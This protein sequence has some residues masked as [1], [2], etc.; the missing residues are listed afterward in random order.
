MNRIL[1]SLCLRLTLMLV[2]LVASGTGRAAVTFQ[3]AGTALA[4]TNVIG[5]LA[6]TWPAHVQGDVALLF[7]ESRAEEAV[8]L[9]Q[10]N[11]FAAVANTPQS[12]GSGLNGT[13]LTVFWA[14]ATSA[15]MLPP[16]ITTPTNHVYARI[17]TYRGVINNGD[18]I[19]AT[20]GDV[21]AGASGSVTVTGVT[22][23]VANTLIV[24]AVARH[25]DN[26]A[27][28]F[29]AQTNINLAGISEQLDAGTAN[30]DGGG[31]GVWSGTKATAGATGDTTA[32][33]TSSINAFVTI[34]LKPQP[35]PRF[36][37]AGT[38]VGN[39]STA[40]PAWPAHAINDIA[41][42]FVESGGGEIVTLSVAAG[43]APVLNSP[44]ATGATTAGTRLT[45][46]WARATSAAMTAPTVTVPVV[47]NS[48]IYA[49]IITFRGVATAGNPWDV[50]GGGVKT[51]TSTVLSVT[52]VS[53]MVAD[54]LLVQAVARDARSTAAYA[55]NQAN[56][57][58]TGIAERVDA[59]TNTGLG[60]GFAVW[61]GYKATAGATG[62]TTATMVNSIN[63][64]LS[65]A[66]IPQAATVPVFN[67]LGTAVVAVAP[68]L[69]WP[70]HLVDDIALVF[71]ESTGGQAV[72]LLQ[73]NGFAA[74]TN[75][76]QATGAGTAGTRISVFWARAT[77]A[78]MLGPILG[79]TTDH[80]YAQIL[81]Y[82]GVVN[83]GNP[84][85]TTAPVGGV[86][87]AASTAVTVTGVTTTYANAMVVQAVARDNDNA[88]A[89]FSAQTNANL[90]SIAERVDAGTTNG[91]GG[92]FSVWDGTKV[93]AGATGNT[94]ATVTSSINAFLTVAL[95]PAGGVAPDH[96]ELSLATDSVSCV[97]TPVTV[98]ACTDT[99]SPC[100]NNF[101]AAS[102]T[103]ATLGTS[104]GALG[105][106]N[107]TFNASGVA[108]TTLNYAAAADG[109]TAI[110]TLSG[111]ALAATNP[112]KCCPDG[113]GCA[114]GNS[115]TTTFKTAGFIF[116]DTA[117]GAAAT[118]PTQVAGTASASLYLRAVKTS[119]TTL[120]CE[121]ALSGANSVNLG[122]TCSN[123]ASCSAGTL[124]DITPYNL[125]DVAQSVVSV[126]PGAG[127]VPLYFDAGANAKLLLNYRDAG[128][129]QVNASKAAGG[130]LLTS[131]SGSSNLFVVRPA[132]F[133]VAATAPFVAGT[134]FGTTVTAR[135]SGGATTPNFG[136]ESTAA[137]VTLASS[138]PLPGSGNATAISTS[139]S[140]FT[141]GV[142]ST[143]LTWNEVGTI[144]LGA[145]IANYLA[146]GVDASGSL[147]AVGPF[148]PAYF[149][150][151]VT[152]A[153]EPTLPL[154]KFTY[155]GLVAPVLAGQSFAVV[156]KAK[157]GGGDATDATNTANYAGATWAKAVTLSD[158]AGGSGTLVNG[159]L[160]AID[161]TAGKASRADLSYRFASKT[162]APY[163]ASIRAVDTDGVSSSGHTEDTALLRSGRLRLSNAVGSPLLAL[164]VPGTMEYFDTTGYWK[165]NSD[166]TCTS[167]LPS[168]FAFN[169]PV[170]SGNSLAACETAVSSAG[171]APNFNTLLLA[172]G[173]ANPGWTDL[174]LNLGAAAVGSTCT[175][176]GP[177]GPAETP[178][179]KP[180]LQFDWK[181]VGLANP[182]ARASFGIHRGNNRII[183]RRER[184]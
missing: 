51:P 115:C 123:P 6:V 149:D 165:T 10:A 152:P 82:R 147:A 3:A 156:V 74:V 60:G 12:T 112:R 124:L 119:T 176:I 55:S 56:G 80:I 42:L 126:P 34:A 2:L 16:I 79:G 138:N 11:G 139:A 24:Q 54:T 46:F 58:L 109:A 20:A 69:S 133:L 62:I 57:S 86:K 61:D 129:I 161:F 63:A 35:G 153:C 41:L 142:S 53:T 154:I 130:S 44:Q 158:V 67:A 88:A 70:A 89:A 116:S 160:A 47:A 73:A 107:V 40:S 163:T 166:D 111:E 29:S 31:L 37:A 137:V 52:S 1:W 162:T 105:T 76:P 71:V 114:V 97:T 14:R 179:N 180:W 157:R 4:G 78:S 150:T 184:Y 43:F 8:T 101:T 127:A 140:G 95:K 164:T 103:T 22:T 21:K 48:H 178:A 77:S 120:A 91:N 18:P 174:T 143:N 117:G 84:W 169:F 131:L 135:T 93:A 167:V 30:G 173:A 108:S 99:S 96:Y 172:P 122:Y 7:V 87:A 50:T 155:A 15:A 151:F 104:A 183:D 106:T 38:A 94:T 148:K 141:A 27:A 85:D 98:T 23:T 113:V 128:R 177:A 33:V 121:A 65:I 75:S 72:T 159:S 19:D 68:L 171:S 28:A 32:T 110:V 45:V 49:Q 168:N 118:I 81:T 125:A 134:A 9:L 144:D 181:G 170:V 59:G 175:A 92:G 39:A 5:G 25:N 146:P 13:R 66:L 26:A 36:Q 132:N 145:S 83:S 17:I 90:S 182:T 64:F 136:Q 102:G 100:T